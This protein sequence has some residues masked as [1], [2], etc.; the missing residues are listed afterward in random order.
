MGCGAEFDS[1]AQL[2]GLRI[3]AVQK[4]APYAQP[5]EEVELRMLYHDTGIRQA[6]EAEGEPRD[7]SIFW[8]AGCENPPGDLYALC[9]EGF[10]QLLSNVELDLTSSNLSDFEPEDVEGLN[11]LLEPIGLRMGVEDTFSMTVAEDIVSRR[12]PTPDSGI[13]PYGLNIVFFAAC[14]GELRLNFDGD[15]F[16]IICVDGDGELLPPKDFV[17]G[18]TSVFT[19]EGLSNDNPVIDGIEVEGKRLPR[20]QF[21]IGA[22]CDVL[23]PDPNRRCGA[24]DVTIARCKDEDDDSK[25]K[26]LDVKVLV[27]PDSVDRDDVISDRQNDELDE[28]MWVNYHTDR[29]KWTFDLALVNGAASG[30]N[31]DP[32]TKYIASTVPGP[33]HVWAVVRDSRGG[34]DWARFQLCV[35]DD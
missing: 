3:M 33:A 34:A 11:A 31:P 22:E 2:E 19:W 20:D 14:A 21:C 29:G 23:E 7:I 1:V 35:E 4:S 25:C 27:D 30:F 9:I 10:R 17:P 28:S 13:P 6:D 15:E 12:P 26:K 24:D 18:Y 16:P 8:L 5:G 32:A